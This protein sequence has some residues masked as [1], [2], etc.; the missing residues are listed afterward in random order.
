MILYSLVHANC[1]FCKY[2]L[3]RCF[4]AQSACNRQRKL[5]SLLRYPRTA[6]E[7]AIILVLNTFEARGTTV[8]D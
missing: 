7:G 5:P 1:W 8:R 6:S 3:L 2:F 4:S